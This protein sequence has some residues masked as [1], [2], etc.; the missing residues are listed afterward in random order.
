MFLV[1]C[2]DGQLPLLKEDM[3]HAELEEEARLAFVGM[4]RA[5]DWL[6][7]SRARRVMVGYGRDDGWKDSQLSR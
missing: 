5:K 4:T 6:H 2:E 3:G 1:A 7:I